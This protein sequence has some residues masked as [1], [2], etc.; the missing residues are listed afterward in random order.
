MTE[1]CLTSG[2]SRNWNHSQ[3]KKSATDGGGAR[4]LSAAGR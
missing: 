4:R 3:V 2:A 1:T